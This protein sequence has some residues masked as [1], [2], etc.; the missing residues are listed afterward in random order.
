MSTPYET[1]LRIQSIGHSDDNRQMTIDCPYC[2]LAHVLNAETFSG[3][4]GGSFQEG[5]WYPYQCTGCAQ[6]IQ[7]TLAFPVC[8]PKVG[9]GYRILKPAH[10]FG[11]IDDKLVH[12]PEEVVHV[13]IE[14]KPETVL[15]DDGDDMPHKEPLPNH[16]AQPH[17]FL[18]RD[19]GNRRRFWM[20]MTGYWVTPLS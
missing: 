17:W 16:L 18:V 9:F 1:S 2:G 8:H 15:V 11:I 5:A 6:Q 13:L 14:P 7:C 4:D 10:S 19:L 12:F 3:L 20:D